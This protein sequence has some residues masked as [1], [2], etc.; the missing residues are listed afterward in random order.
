MYNINI[1]ENFKSTRNN[2]YKLI[3][4]YLQN[5]SYLSCYQ[6]Y[7]SYFCTSKNL[8]YVVLYGTKF[9]TLEQLKAKI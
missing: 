8:D 3:A 4:V 6:F 2:V 7:T 5:Y 9:A 1:N